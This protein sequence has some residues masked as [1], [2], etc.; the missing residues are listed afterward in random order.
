MARKKSAT[1]D[2][3]VQSVAL[4]KFGAKALDAA[5]QVRFKKKAVEQFPLEEGERVITAELPGLP[6]TLKKKLAKKT[7]IFA[8]ADTANRRQAAHR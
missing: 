3:T 8:V 4:H 7:S 2:L 1:T 5:E 6:A